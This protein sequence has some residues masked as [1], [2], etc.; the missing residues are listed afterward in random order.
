M[1]MFNAIVADL[2]KTTPDSMK[3]GR[4]WFSW[5]VTA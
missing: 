1:A 5:M 3:E 2:K 4:K